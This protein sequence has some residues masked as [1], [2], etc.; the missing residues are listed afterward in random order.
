[1]KSLLTLLMWA[2]IVGA[3]MIAIATSGC[4]SSG[5]WVKKG[6]DFTQTKK[7]MD[8]CEDHT[9]FMTKGRSFTNFQREFNWCMKVRG[10]EWEK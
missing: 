2:V 7:D 10:Y 1:M 3:L 5:Q 9:K 6:S 4:S 8:H